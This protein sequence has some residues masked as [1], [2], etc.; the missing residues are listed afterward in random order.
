MA[1]IALTYNLNSCLSTVFH[2][3]REWGLEARGGLPEDE[4]CLVRALALAVLLRL[5]LEFEGVGRVEVHGFREEGGFCVEP[6][7]YL[8]VFKS[9]S[10][11]FVENSNINGTYS[12]TSLSLLPPGFFPVTVS[13]ASSN[14][15][16]E[17][18]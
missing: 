4:E 3:E 10:L 8:L 1:D 13:L 14:P 2:G 15:H 11:L 6:I 17:A 7:V 16:D 12:R 9:I 5:K 18:A